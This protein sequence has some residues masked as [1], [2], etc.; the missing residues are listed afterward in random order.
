MYM[1][2]GKKYLVHLLSFLFIY[3]I[4]IIFIIIIF[5]I[6]IF[7]KKTLIKYYKAILY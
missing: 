4:I 7:M 2:R 3:F 1:L 6:I 5:I